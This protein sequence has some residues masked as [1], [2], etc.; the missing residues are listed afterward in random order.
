MTDGF[1]VVAATSEIQEDGQMFVEL[2]GE[3]ILL[4]KHGGQYH[5]VAYLCSHAEFSLEGG[6][7]HNGCITC[8][9]HGAEFSLTTGEALA[10]PA[11][12]PIKTYPV[13][14]ADGVISVCAVAK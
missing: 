10:A 4:V 1:Y 3:D 9:Y 7:L 8:P 2:D 6:S 11:Y 13:R 12:E 5:A 14:V